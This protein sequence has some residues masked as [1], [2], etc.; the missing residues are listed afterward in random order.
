M[1]TQP[2]PPSVQNPAPAVP[3]GPVST[4]PAPQKGRVWL[5]ILLVVVFLGAY[6]AYAYHTAMW[7][8]SPTAVPN[9]SPTPTASENPLPTASATPDTSAWK[10]YT[11]PGSGFSF[12]YPG[13]YRIMDDLV[14]VDTKTGT[15]DFRPT[16]KALNAGLSD[17][18]PQLWVGVTAYAT[19]DASAQSYCVQEMKLNPGEYKSEQDCEM[20]G[21][22]PLTKESQA[23]RRSRLASMAAAAPGTDYA[24][25]EVVVQ[26]GGMKF[27]R[28]ISLS[29]QSDA[30]ST[31]FSTFDAAG[32]ELGV[33]I[34]YDQSYSDTH[35]TDAQLMSS[36]A[37]TTLDAIL[38]TFTLTNPTAGWKTYTN[39]KFGFSVRYP[40]GF[41]YK[42][43]AVDSPEW[44]VGFDNQPLNSLDSDVTTYEIAI[45][46]LSNKDHVTAG[47][48][49]EAEYGGASPF[50]DKKLLQIG[51]YP[52][53][54]SS[55]IP[56]IGFDV[57]ETDILKG[58]YVYAVWLTDA[59]SLRAVYNQLLSSF[60]FTK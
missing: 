40:Q 12:K 24:N 45:R 21:I 34:G 35:P 30:Y 47:Q 23:A 4:I 17:D 11:D 18:A 5:W 46:V 25:Q 55:M 29:P 10:T 59:V 20:N 1:D 31:N 15:S 41:N 37:N 57:T 27:Y 14:V 49:L 8:F 28:S 2:L 60:T 56:S 43:R 53:V 7:P 3:P 33:S 50:T 6:G 32:D 44:A 19:L 42:E 52:A 13:N 39:A 51:G 54:Q 48:W 22:L 16:T 26:S 36:D 58:D 9:A 38:S